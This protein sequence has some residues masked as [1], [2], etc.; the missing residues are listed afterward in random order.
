MKTSYKML[1]IDDNLKTLRGVKRDFERYFKKHGI[2]FEPIEIEQNPGI[3]VIE[4]PKF[5]SAVEDIELDIVLIDFHMSGETGADII[6]HIR[7]NLHHYHIPI[8]FY[9]GDGPQK[10]QEIIYKSNTDKYNIS[11]GIYFCDRDNIFQKTR[12]ILD[13]LIKREERP[14]RVRGLLMDRVSEIDAL[15]LKILNSDILNNMTDEQINGLKKKYIIEKL[16]DKE[17]H[18]R[19]LLE[20]LEHSS[21]NDTVLYIVNNPCQFDSHMRAELLRNIYRYIDSEKGNILSS[22]YNDVN[23]DEKCLSKLR[24]DYAHQTEFEI[25]A[26]HTSNRCKYIREE[27]RKHLTNLTEINV[28][29]KSKN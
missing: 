24:N 26:F 1:W 25:A 5:L 13:S 6:N 10:I 29:L 3:V 20:K 2:I 14:Q 9:S 18:A 16:K 15:I 28:T 21:F 11:D 23:Q 17:N 19:V 12:N 22:F 8:L 4:E 7:K 27:S